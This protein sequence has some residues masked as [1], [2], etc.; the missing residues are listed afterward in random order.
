MIAGSEQT[1]ARPDASAGQRPVPPGPH[2]GR[3]RWHSRRA[4]LELD[5]LFERFWRRNEQ[6]LDIEQA[7]LLEELLELE[8]HELWDMLC[9]RLEIGD[10]RWRGL[11]QQLLEV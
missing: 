6:G 5:L 4:L 11:M 9:G 3:L 10:S 8:D 1:T 2:L 7:I